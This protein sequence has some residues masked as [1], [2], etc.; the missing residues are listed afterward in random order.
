MTSLKKI[1]GIYHTPILAG[2]K[3]KWISTG[4]TH[5]AEAEAVL[6]ESGVDKLNVAAKANN[7]TQRAIGQILTGKNLTCEKALEKYQKLKAVSKSA[8][9]VSNNVLVVGNWLAEAGLQTMPPSSVTVDHIN[10]WINN[11]DLEWKRSTRLVALASVRSF[12]EFCGHQGWIVT[13]PS[14]LVELDY[15]AMTHEQK[16]GNEKQPFT[17][18]ELARLLKALRNDLKLAAVKKHELFQDA[19]HILFWLVAVMV[20]KETGLRLSDVAQLEW[21]CFGEPGKLVV[22]TE[23]TNR[24]IEHIISRDIQNI[25]GDVPVI[26]PDYIFP[27]QRATIRNIA[28]RS[29]LSVQFSR[30]LD[31][32]GIKGK[33]FHSIRHFKASSAFKNIKKEDL[34]KKLAE[35]LSMAEIA[36]LLGHSSTKTTKGYVHE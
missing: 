9:T 36:T 20:S 24:R 16:E 21:R 17:E 35:T 32:V 34:A 30:L 31:R 13:D 14:Q 23:K 2:G 33:S 19:S 7:L 4:A 18:E 5:K 28:K 12:F 22:W 3:K 11:P 1:D 10:R 8:K 6:E 26:D 15:S 27:E 25:I 29:L